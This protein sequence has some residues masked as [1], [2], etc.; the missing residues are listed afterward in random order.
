M[1]LIKI[2]TILSVIGFEFEKKIYDERQYNKSL[3]KCKKIN[4]VTK[5]CHLKY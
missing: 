2:I 5:R 3:K 1:F 4:I